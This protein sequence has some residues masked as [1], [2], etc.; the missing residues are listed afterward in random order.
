M[1]LERSFGLFLTL[2]QEKNKGNIWLSAL[3]QLKVL[4]GRRK[5]ILGLTNDMLEDDVELELDKI[6]SL[7][8]YIWMQGV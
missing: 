6:G 5:M 3:L 4:Q 2:F 7:E 1:S 8:P